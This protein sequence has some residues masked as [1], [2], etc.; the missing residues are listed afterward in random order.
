MGRAPAPE[1][2]TN[3]WQPVDKEDR[4]SRTTEENSR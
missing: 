3:G 2:Y 4:T 1:Y